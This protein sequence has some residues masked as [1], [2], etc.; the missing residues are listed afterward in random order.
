MRGCVRGREGGCVCQR[1][2]LMEGERGKSSRV[3]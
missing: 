2:G 1:E 3:C